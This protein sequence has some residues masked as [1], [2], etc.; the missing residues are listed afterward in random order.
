V[1]KITF[2]ILRTFIIS[3]TAPLQA[4]TSAASRNDT[5]MVLAPDACGPHGSSLPGN[6]GDLPSLYEYL[7]ITPEWKQLFSFARDS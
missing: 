3:L 5:T 4:V 2:F 1:R 6:S 7:K